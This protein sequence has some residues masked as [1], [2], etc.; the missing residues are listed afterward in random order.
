NLDAPRAR[1]E[2]ILDQFLHRAGGPLHHFAGGDTV[3]G[4]LSQLAN[5]AGA[6]RFGAHGGEFSRATA[7]SAVC[8]GPSTAQLCGVPGDA[9]PAAGAGVCSLGLAAVVEATG[10]F[11]PGAGVFGAEG[12]GGG[13][14]GTG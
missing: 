10:G 2:G 7:E 4:A 13:C 14:A 11:G 6:A 9:P 3:D 12:L 5:T 8:R 1:I